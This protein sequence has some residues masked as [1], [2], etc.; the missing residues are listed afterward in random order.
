MK[1]IKALLSLLFIICILTT[2][3]NCQDSIHILKESIK[4]QQNNIHSYDIDTAIKDTENTTKL[5]KPQSIIDY[6]VDTVKNILTYGYKDL[7]FLIVI[8]VMS[9]V[10]QAFSSNLGSSYG[11]VNYISVLMTV[12]V[13]LRL[14]TPLLL[15]ISDFL[16]N[17]IIFMTSVSSCTGILLAGSGAV[18]TAA[19]ASA[20]SSFITGF[21]QICATAIIIPVIKIIIALSCV[22]ALNDYGDFSGIIGF[23]KSFCTY[24]LG[25]LFAVFLGVH[26]VSVSISTS[27]DSLAF[28][29]IRF[30]FARLIPVAGGMISES[31]KTVLAGTKVIKNAYGGIGIAY[32]IYM[33]I[34][35]AISILWVKISL[36]IALNIAKL[37]NIKEISGFL[38]GLSNACNLI[39]AIC[40]FAA[41]GGIIILAVFMNISM[42]A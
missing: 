1:K 9:A 31:I 10:T 36:L 16:D 33:I 27:T 11:S 38:D 20:Y 13:G 26:A 41:F 6:S 19:T 29:A 37:F 35:V 32:I 5:L 42:E 23:L 14:I 34:P 28:R 4:N 30:T 40:I 7:C 12:F 18:T 2:V 24:G 8:I 3:C 17:H 21:T 25:L 22:N 39:I 15:S